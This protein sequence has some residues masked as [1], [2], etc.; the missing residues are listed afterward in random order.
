MRGAYQRNPHKEHG[1]PQSSAGGTQGGLLLV[2]LLYT[3]DS[4]VFFISGCQWPHWTEQGTIGWMDLYYGDVCISAFLFREL[5]ANH[6]FEK[7]WLHT[8]SYFSQFSHHRLATSSPILTTSE[9]YAI[10]VG[11]MSSPTWRLVIIWCAMPN[12]LILHK[13]DVHAI[14][15][16]I[17]EAG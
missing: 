2:S 5:S 9:A 10:G 13:S 6:D 3:L 1:H 16:G 12:L 11:G 14:I 15:I 4:H 7:L 17:W 8:C